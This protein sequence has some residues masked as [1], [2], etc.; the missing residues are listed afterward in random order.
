LPGISCPGGDGEVLKGWP[1]L[2]KELPICAQL[3]VEG[4]QPY[5]EEFVS[6]VIWVMAKLE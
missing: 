1:V 5:A 4:F 3:E 6:G 2:G